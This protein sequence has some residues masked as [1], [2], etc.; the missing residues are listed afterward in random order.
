[1]IHSLDHI[2]RIVILINNE[3]WFGSPCVTSLELETEYERKKYSPK[4]CVESTKKKLKWKA[5]WINSFTIHIFHVCFIYIPIFVA[6]FHLPLKE[7]CIHTLSPLHCALQRASWQKGTN[8]ICASRIRQVLE[9][10][11]SIHTVHLHCYPRWRIVHV[12]GISRTLMNRIEKK[13]QAENSKCWKVN[14]EN[15]T[16]RTRFVYCTLNGF[17]KWVRLPDIM[18]SS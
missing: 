15:V 9:K 10:I 5:L 3:F 6:C 1:M 17:M 11:V 4:L 8:N 14:V 12:D 7:L 16:C 18:L 13:F 2:I